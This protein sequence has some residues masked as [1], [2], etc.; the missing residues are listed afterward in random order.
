MPFL[1]SL[2]PLQSCPAYSCLICKVKLKHSEILQLVRTRWE[3]Q[4]DVQNCKAAAQTIPL[5][6]RRLPSFLEQCTL[7]ESK[8][9][10]NLPWFLWGGD[11]LS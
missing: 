3:G 1:V 2:F 11:S 9:K 7:T 4:I 10:T 8:L 6:Y 5:V